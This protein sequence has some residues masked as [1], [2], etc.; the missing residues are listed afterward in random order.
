MESMDNR[1]DI[2]FSSVIDHFSEENTTS[3]EKFFAI[4]IFI[5][6]LGF[7]LVYPALLRI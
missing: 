7:H 4:Y 6:T 1:G 3:I 2:S 5:R